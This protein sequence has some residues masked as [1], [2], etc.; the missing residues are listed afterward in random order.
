MS[1]KRPSQILKLRE[2]E[3]EDLLSALSFFIREF[4]QH[5]PQTRKAMGML[6]KKLWKVIRSFRDDSMGEVRK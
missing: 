6:E 2:Q 5:A 3:C 1:K 4:P